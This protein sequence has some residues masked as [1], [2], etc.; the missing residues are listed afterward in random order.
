MIF[1][2]KKLHPDAVAPF[3]KHYNDAGYDLTAVLIEKKDKYVQYNTGIAVEIPDG[4]VGLI[5]PRSSV[6]KEDLMLKNSVGV[7]DS[8]YQG[9]I[10]FR[11][12]KAVND[13]FKADVRTSSRSGGSVE[14]FINMYSPDRTLD[15]YKVGDRIG[16]IMFIKLPEITLE[17]VD[18]F[19]S[20]LRGTEGF[21]STGK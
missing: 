3:R 19:S 6:T 5:F 17:L 10:R 13:A 15:L 12:I 4:Y 20:S 7:I 14:R 18:E 9:E 2:Y 11:F 16:Q 21:G 8:G 1:K